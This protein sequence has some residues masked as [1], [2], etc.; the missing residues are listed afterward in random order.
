MRPDWSTL[1]QTERDTTYNN[2]LAVADSAAL[3]ERRN[4]ASAALRAERSGHLDVPY[5]PRERNK[6]DLYPAEDPGAP[7]LVFIHGGYWQRNTREDFATFARGP[8]GAGRSVAM[9]GYSLAP[10]VTLTDIVDEISAMLDRLVAIGSEHGLAQGKIIISGWSAGA[11]LA[12]LALAHPA[13]SAGLAISGVY[14]LAPIRDTFLNEKLAL[15]DR[16]IAELSPL[17]L[18]VVDKP[19]AIAYGTRE[20][21]MLIED[22]RELHGRRAAAH[23]SGALLPIAGADHFTILEQFERPDSELMQQLILL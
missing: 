14:A 3:I 8:L 23:A 11:H 22:S 19:M 5:G 15:S 4:A 18:P 16:E 9:P 2:N 7:C 21:P 17:N 6:I 13:I 12:A 20:L 1:G 10:D